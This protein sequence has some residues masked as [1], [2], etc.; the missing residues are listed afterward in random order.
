M[1]VEG[2]TS[3]ALKVSENNINVVNNNVVF[4]WNNANGVNVNDGEVLFTLTLKSNADTKLS[5][6]LNLNDNVARTEAYTGSD[7]DIYNINLEYRNSA[8]SYALYQ[9]EP[10][11]FTDETVI[12]FDLPEAG[13]YTLTVYDVTGKVLVVRNA[14]GKAGYNTEKLS[15]KDIN[16]NG[17][18]YYRL[19]SGDYTATKKMIVIK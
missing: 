13:A 10:N 3:G 6:V 17:V 7:L 4:S 15:K 9:N 16:T 8:V 12:G 5:S 19:E 14:E 1:E 18:L 11:P 2:I